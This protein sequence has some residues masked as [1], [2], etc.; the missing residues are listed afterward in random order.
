ML[1]VT[2]DTHFGHRNIFGPKG[3]EQSRAH[4]KSADQMNETIIRNWNNKV[5]QHDTVIHAGDVALHMTPKQVFSLLKRLNGNIEIISGNHDDSRTMKYLLHNNYIYNR[6]PKFTIHDIG[7][8]M[9]FN[10]KDYY[11][12]HYPVA[13]GA[14]RGRLRNVCGHIH[15]NPTDAPNQ[16]NIGIDSPEIGRRPFG[17]P[18]RFE[19]VVQLM[20]V[21][22]QK[23]REKSDVDVR[24]SRFKSSD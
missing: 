13:L 20:N 8:R 17:E 1:Y 5:T 2:S 22:W 16:L 4:F 11:I 15:S 24:E 9:K 14:R 19:E 12:T 23:S 3:F 18:I 10:K 6:K 21:K 7:V